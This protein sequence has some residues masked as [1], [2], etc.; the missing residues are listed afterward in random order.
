VGG[1]GTV[2]GVAWADYDQDG[3]LDLYVAVYDGANRLYRNDNIPFLAN[4]WLGVDLVGTASNRAGIGARVRCVAGGRQAIREISGGS[5]YL[6]QEPLTARFGL[7]LTAAVD[8]LEIRWPS[9]IVQVLTNPAI[10]QRLTVT[11]QQTSS[12]PGA[13]PLPQAYSLY[14][15]VPN[16]FNPATVIGFDLP[17]PGTVQLTVIDVA[18]RPVRK[19]LAGSERPAGHHQVTWDGRSDQGNS[20]ASGIYFYRIVANDF[21]ATRR[22]TLLK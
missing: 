14:A 17:T 20:V 22:M 2:V 3:D 10:D 9:G 11:E 7:G 8:T 13:A 15:N 19:L 21:R 5:G 12:T 6:S 18:G 4:H 1:S 16:P